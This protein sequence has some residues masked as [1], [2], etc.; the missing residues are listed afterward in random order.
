[1]YPATPVV[2]WCDQSSDGGERHHLK[3]ISLALLL[4]LLLLQTRLEEAVRS[5][6]HR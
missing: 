4:F 6:G 5:Q 2:L 3:H 1:M